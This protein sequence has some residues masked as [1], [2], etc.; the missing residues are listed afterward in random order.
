MNVV[1]VAINVHGCPGEDDSSWLD[2]VVYILKVGPQ[3][4]SGDWG[5]QAEHPLMLLQPNKSVE[6][7]DTPQYWGLDS[8]QAKGKEDGIAAHDVKIALPSDLCGK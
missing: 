6:A 8:C 4:A 2:L 5:H 1:Q 3:Q 7:L